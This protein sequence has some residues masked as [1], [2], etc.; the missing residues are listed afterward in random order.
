ML[1]FPFRLTDAEFAT[2]LRLNRAF[3]PMRWKLY[4]LVIA[5][6]LP[7][8]ATF[9]LLEAGWSLAWFVIMIGV[10]CVYAISAFVKKS[11]GVQN[12]DQRLTLSESHI[13]IEF[14]HSQSELKWGLFDEIEET[15]DSLR[16]LRLQR[17]SYFPKRVFGDHLDE[18]RTLISKGRQT[19]LS[20]APT[21]NLYRQIYETDSCFPTYEFYY[22]LGGF[23]GC[24]QI[25]F[26][27]CPRYRIGQIRNRHL[28]AV[29]CP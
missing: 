12:C 3:I 23:G 4:L 14:S 27:A 25:S 10:L 2:S 8:L 20:S 24:N 17:Y 11:G 7:S 18:C 16:F 1:Q 26:S 15:A 13:S 5:S 28:G 29:G 19:P 9:Y 6:M 21:V 22:C